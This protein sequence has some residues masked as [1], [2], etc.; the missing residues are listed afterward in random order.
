MSNLPPARLLGTL[1]ESS[2]F[3]SISQ[4]Y[5]EQ[6]LRAICLAGYQRS[7]Y[8]TDG[9]VMIVPQRPGGLSYD[10]AFAHD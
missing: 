10:M 2:F 5:R 6:G 8:F 4:N 9:G 7:G 3:E 1:V